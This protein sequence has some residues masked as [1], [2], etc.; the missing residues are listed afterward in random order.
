MAAAETTTAAERPRTPRDL[1]LDGEARDRIPGDTLLP[2]QVSRGTPEPK[3]EVLLLVALLGDA[4]ELAT[5]THHHDED[6]ADARQWIADFDDAPFGFAWVCDQLGLDAGLIRRRVRRCRARGA[7]IE[8]PI[9]QSEAG[10]D[11]PRTIQRLRS[12]DSRPRRRGVFA[13]IPSIGVG[14]STRTFGR[15]VMTS[16]AARTSTKPPISRANCSLTSFGIVT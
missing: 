2:T 11:G 10:P 12:G 7:T 14:R 8:A 4:V 16:P 1:L 13:T 15:R 5:A 6:M 9:W 3:P